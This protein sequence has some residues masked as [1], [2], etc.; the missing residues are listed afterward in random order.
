MLL[1]AGRE[2]LDTPIDYGAGILMRASVGEQVDAGQAL[3]ELCIGRHARLEDA[4]ALAASAF[5]IGD[6]PPPPRPWCTT[7]WADCQPDQPDQPANPI[8]RG[9]RDH[10]ALR[11]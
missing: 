5:V 11:L 10:R 3:A 7:S 4:R 1:G 9:H 6:A 2:R 8:N